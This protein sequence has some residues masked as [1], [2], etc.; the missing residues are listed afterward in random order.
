V[1]VPQVPI[2][3]ADEDQRAWLAAERREAVHRGGELPVQVDRLP[4]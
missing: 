1:H 2:L 4:L 3:L